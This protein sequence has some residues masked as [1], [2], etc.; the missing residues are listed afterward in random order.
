MTMTLIP[1]IRYDS[2]VCLLAHSP[3]RD[4]KAKRAV[5]V[6]MLM[7]IVADLVQCCES[8]VESSERGSLAECC[9]RIGQC[10]AKGC[11]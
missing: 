4:K 5:R 11:P 9:E 10:R 6:F 2:I 1:A 7:V 3:I 8:G